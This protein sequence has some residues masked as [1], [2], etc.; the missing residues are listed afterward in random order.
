VFTALCSQTNV[1]AV[2]LDMSRLLS[3]AVGVVSPAD[4]LQSTSL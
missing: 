3:V 4:T 1:E 2:A